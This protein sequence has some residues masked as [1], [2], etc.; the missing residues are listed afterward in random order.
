MEYADSTAA[1]SFM[2]LV[3]VAVVGVIWAIY[4]LVLGNTGLGVG[5]LVTSLVLFGGAWYYRRTANPLRK[6]FSTSQYLNR[7]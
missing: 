1:Y 7:Y 4:S 5:V 2:A 3:V 6:V